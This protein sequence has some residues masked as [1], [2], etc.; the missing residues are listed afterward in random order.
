M[1]RRCTMFV[2]LNKCAQ[3][4]TDLLQVMRSY[5]KQTW[6]SLFPSNRFSGGLRLFLNKETAT[7][8]RL[9]V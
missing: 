7:A 2:V 1:S 9:V 8:K 3:I 4:R 5:T 6:Q